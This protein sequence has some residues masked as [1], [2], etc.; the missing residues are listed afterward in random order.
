MKFGYVV[1][2]DAE[3]VRMMNALNIRAISPGNSYQTA[4]Q[5][6]YSA[7]QSRTLMRQSIAHIGNRS[8]GLGV[9]GLIFAGG[10]LGQ[11]G[12][13]YKKAAPGTRGLKAANFSAGVAGLLGAC[14]ETVGAAGSRLPWFSQNRSTPNRWFARK[15]TTRAAMISAVGRSLTAVGGVVIGAVMVVEGWRETSLSMGYGIT[16]VGLG[17][18]S[19]LAAA[20]LFFGFA[21]PAAVILLIIVAVVS[22]VVSWFKPDEIQRWLDKVMRFGKN[23]SGVYPDLDTQGNVLKALQQ[24]R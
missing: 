18:A 19:V 16:I 17:I 12:S 10:S 9:V 5:Q 11:L 13:E 15:A 20:M 4:L 1:L 7:H 22:V 23:A 6:H 2:A 3:H 21:I 8:L 24:A 14:A